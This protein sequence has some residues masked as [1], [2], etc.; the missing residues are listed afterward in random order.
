VSLE[1]LAD[2]DGQSR[3]SDAS[4]TDIVRDALHASTGAL[5]SALL[6]DHWFVAGDGAR[7]ALE[8]LRGAGLVTDTGAV[9]SVTYLATLS[10]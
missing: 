4:I 6:A 10:R 3:R 2:S 1:V 7:P 9:V 8:R 5:C